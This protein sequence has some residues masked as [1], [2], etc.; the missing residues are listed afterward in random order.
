MKKQKNIVQQFKDV[1]ANPKALKVGH[2]IKFDMK[3]LMLYGVEVADPIYDT[4]VA[5]YIFKILQSLELV[6]VKAVLVGIRPEVAQ[7][8]VS[9]GIDFR[10]VK[11]YSTMQ[12]AL[13][14][15]IK[16]ENLIK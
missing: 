11:T 9:L 3:V 12:Q 4:M 8:M 15:Y 2:N 10:E 6:G 7:T 1:F 14:M 13:S 16:S 5:H